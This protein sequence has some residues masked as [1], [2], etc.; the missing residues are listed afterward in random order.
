LEP[1]LTS[2]SDLIMRNPQY[3]L[4]IANTLAKTPPAQQIYYATAL[5]KATEGWTP[6]LYERYFKWFYGA[7]G[8]KGGNSFVG[9]L[10]AVRKL[11]LENV[12]K[13]QFAHYNTI[14]GDSLLAESGKDLF[15]NVEPPKGPGKNWKIED[16]LKAV[17]EDKGKRDF[18]RGKELFVAIRCASCHTMH[19]EGGAIG[20][21]LTQLGTRF[22]VRD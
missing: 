16:A 22:S 8:Y 10:D 3:G 13:A 2:S 19:G 1:I 12:P 14:S 9:F 11:A 17:E 6:E 7:F 18:E 15:Q 5:S 21:D 20:P 4:D